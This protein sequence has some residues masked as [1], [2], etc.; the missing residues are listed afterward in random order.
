M[1]AS[2]NKGITELRK[3]VAYYGLETVQVRAFG[4]SITTGRFK[5]SVSG[6]LHL[7]GEGDNNAGGT[8]FRKSTT[9]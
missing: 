9:S 5:K 1:L 2:N 7:Q 3:M 8:L 4:R 6:A